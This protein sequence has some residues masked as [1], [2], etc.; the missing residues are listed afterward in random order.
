MVDFFSLFL[1]RYHKHPKTR[2]QMVDNLQV[3]FKFM[4][5]EKLEHTSMSES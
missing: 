5:A 1:C 2:V 3:A 4:E